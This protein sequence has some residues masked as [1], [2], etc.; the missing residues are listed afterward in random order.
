MLAGAYDF[1]LAEPLDQLETLV[2]KPGCTIPLL[3]CQ[4]PPADNKQ[5]VPRFELGR[6]LIDLA[7]A[8]SVAAHDGCPSNSPSWTAKNHE[9]QSVEFSV[10]YGDTRVSGC[11]RSCPDL[12]FRCA[13]ELLIDR[14]LARFDR[15]FEFESWYFTA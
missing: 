10:L 14:Q 2:G 13:H 7:A 3:V 12:A 8:P 6:V 4:Q 15:S 11:A 5:R 9:A 1:E